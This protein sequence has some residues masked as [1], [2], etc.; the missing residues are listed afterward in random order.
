MESTTIKLTSNHPDH[1]KPNCLILDEID[2]AD[3]KGAIQSLVEIIRAELPAKG[4]KKKTA[5]Y[6]RRPIIFICNHKYAPALR[7]LLPVARHFNVDPPSA[8]RLVA[9]LK[10]VLSREK[11]NMMAGGSL[12]HQLVLSSGGDIR[13]SLFSLQF[14]SAQALQAKD[15]SADISQAL[16]LSLGG[17]G[18][19]DDRGDMA[20][21]L[22]TVFRK[23]KTKA[24]NSLVERDDRASVT[25]VLNAVE[26]LN[27]DSATMNA[28]FLNLPRVSYIDPTFD[29][30]SAA[31][32]WL[33]GADVL[34]SGGEG[35]GSTRLHT[36]SMAAAIHLLCRVELKPDLNFSTREFSDVYYQ[37][38][39]NLGLVQKFSEG[40]PAKAKGMKCQGLLTTELV[41]YAL[42]M[43]SAGTGNASLSRAASSIDILTKLERESVDAHVSL[44][45]ALGL[46][47]LS[48]V[49]EEPEFN[50]KRKDAFQH[51]ASMQ[52]QMVLEPPI[53]RLVVYRQLK[54]FPDLRRIPI[55]P[56]VSIIYY[57]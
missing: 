20:A 26:G 34:G 7:P 16:T 47:Y 52:K 39:T 9:R 23:V 46:T 30:C 2:G 31:H 28:L 35:Y 11:I 53:D 19:K 1:G 37:R 38:E 42:W 6:L 5:P 51:T 48:T 14:A 17:S 57:I 49:V 29:R 4:S 45:R 24:V 36:P 55:P 32:E 15:T 41:P 13:S 43:L 10:A 3:A 27:D 50:Q 22:T 25:R 21:T 44:L 8:S 54:Q 40:L 18:L 33:S 12:L 56:A